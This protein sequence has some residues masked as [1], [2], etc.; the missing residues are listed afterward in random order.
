[1]TVG[2]VFGVS[3]VHHKT[4]SIYN[5][6]NGLSTGRK[7]KATIIAGFTGKGVGMWVRF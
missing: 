2:F 4:N 7:D 5:Y 1:M 3:S 6:N